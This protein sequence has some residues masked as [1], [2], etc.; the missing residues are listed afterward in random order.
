LNP[1]DAAHAKA[2]AASQALS[3]TLV[4][5]A[6]VMVEVGDAM[7]NPA[8]R[9][10]FLSLLEDLRGSPQVRI[11]DPDE[12]LFQEGVKLYGS[13]L[14]KDWSLTDCMSFVVMQREGIVEALTGDHH[15]TQA[16][17]TTLLG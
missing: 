4:T 3:G 9:S 10:V 6:W 14:D 5:T 11:I 17:F 16:G 12:Q 7:A 8:N 1:R 13:R 2:L 15:Y